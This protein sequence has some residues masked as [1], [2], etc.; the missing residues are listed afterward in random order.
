MELPNSTGALTNRNNPQHES[1]PNLASVKKK[2]DWKK[3]QNNMVP[4]ES[5]KKKA[6]VVDWLA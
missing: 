4:R 5:P 1:A 3:F 6:Q 2:V